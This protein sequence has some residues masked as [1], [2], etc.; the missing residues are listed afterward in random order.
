MSSVT[1]PFVQLENISKRFGDTIA[2]EQANLVLTAGHIHAILGE[3]GAGKTT[4]MRILAGVIRPDFGCIRLNGHPVF[5]RHARDALSAGIGMVHQHFMLVPTLSVAENVWLSSAHIPFILRRKK[6]REEIEHAAHQLGFKLPL[7]A[8][9]GSL[10]LGEQQRVEILRVLHRGV[11]LLI[12]DEPT[13]V[14]SPADVETLFNSLRQLTSHGCTVVL[15]SH[16][17]EEIRQIAQ[18]LTIMRRG[19]I[20]ATIENPADHSPEELAAA[21]VGHHITLQ[22]DR[23]EFRPGPIILNTQGLC[24]PSKRG[25]EAV[26]HVN[27]Q[28]HQGEIVGLAGV[29]G[30]GQPELMDALAGLCR[31]SR[32]SIQ[33]KEKDI[34]QASPRQRADLGLRY[35]P[36]DRHTVGTASALTI[37]ENLLLRHYYQAPCR[38]GMWLDL[39]QMDTYCL[40]K[41]A[42]LHLEAS[43]LDQSVASLSGGNLQKIV[44][45]RE[46]GASAKVI[47]AMHPTRGLDA[48]ATTEVH[49]QLLAAREHGAGI[50]LC[51][52]DLD[53][54]MALSDRIAVMFRGKLVYFSDRHPHQ[55]RIISQYMLGARQA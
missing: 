47:L 14:L 18:S 46:L 50:L 12:M 41:M 17:L 33:L 29:A 23:T 53:E 13:A 35:I 30:N 19:H 28:I 24:V 20:V 45:A 15:I 34:S 54:L 7:D 43:G 8:L 16:K 48:W 3:N 2:V 9:V 52:E 38:K 10:S 37:A 1:A 11:K 31:Q 4:L 44:V 40:D 36:E 42:G 51:S 49:R 26:N 22:L 55:T 39:H 5:F 25:S 21:M 27:L 32:G 6:W